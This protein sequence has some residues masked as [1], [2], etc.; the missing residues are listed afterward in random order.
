METGNS[1][2]EFVSDTQVIKWV[3]V[4]NLAPIVREAYVYK[5][6]HATNEPSIVVSAL[7]DVQYDAAKQMFGFLMNRADG[8]LDHYMTCWAFRDQWPDVE[9]L[10]P[11]DLMFSLLLSL[12]RIHKYGVVHR[13]IKPQ[14]ILLFRD[15]KKW[16]VC[17]ADY[18]NSSI[19]FKY[20]AAT[21]LAY[22]TPVC[23]EVY[24][25][26]E[27]STG[28][29]DEKFDVYSLAA[30]VVHY[31]MY[32]RRVRSLKHLTE[33]VNLA[34]VFQ[35]GIRPVNNAP[36]AA[37]VQQMLH[38]NSKERPSVADLLSSP[39]FQRSST[40][41]ASNIN[42]LR[43]YDMPVDPED[44]KIIRFGSFQ[45]TEGTVDH[46]IAVCA[47]SLSLRE[48]TYRTIMMMLRTCRTSGSAAFL[49]NKCINKI[50]YVTKKQG[51]WTI[52]ALSVVLACMEPE[53][54]NPLDLKDLVGGYIEKCLPDGVYKTPIYRAFTPKAIYA[55]IFH[56]LSN[57]FEYELPFQYGVGTYRSIVDARLGTA[58]AKESRQNDWFY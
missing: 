12:H 22:T 2:I 17:L 39:V 28:L 6:L 51:L 13:D 44:S 58:V 31:I 29:L 30:T 48:C 24:A 43:K 27:N 46:L 11:V 14:N 8:D 32:D 52:A 10:E 45:M 36:F 18:G 21:R 15:N 41:D 23:T 16:S 20:D 57:Q 54:Y 40:A 25:P 5:C 9:P 33:D 3:S 42:N 35:T 56:V 7:V 53:W 26:P 19:A 4:D 49:V 38:P 50:P 1:I 47:L 37:L 55:S 34:T